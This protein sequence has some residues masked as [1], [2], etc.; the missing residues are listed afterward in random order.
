MLKTPRLQLLSTTQRGDKDMR[1]KMRKDAPM[2]ALRHSSPPMTCGYSPIPSSW[3][4]SILPPLFLPSQ[5]PFFMHRG[6]EERCGAS[7]VTSTS[8]PLL[9]PCI[10]PPPHLSSV[11]GRSRTILYLP[12]S[13]PCHR[14]MCGG[15]EER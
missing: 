11:A 6:G 15:G 1:L 9:F 12:F 5:A 4:E 14:H 13:S 7:P 3:R 10:P 2:P 8:R